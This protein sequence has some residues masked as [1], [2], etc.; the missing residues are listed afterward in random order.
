MEEVEGRRAA[1]FPVEFA[2]QVQGGIADLFG[3]EALP[4]HAPEEAV[5]G[6]EAGCHE[7]GVVQHPLPIGPAGQDEA[8]QLLE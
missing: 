7:A 5:V 4:V 3:A 1:H 2:A 6:I 8:V